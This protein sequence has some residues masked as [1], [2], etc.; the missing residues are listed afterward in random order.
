[1]SRTFNAISPA[2]NIAQKYG[3]DLLSPAHKAPLQSLLTKLYRKPVEL[4]LIKIRRPQLE[5]DVLASYVAQRLGDRVLQPR[6]VIRD[7]AWK[8][9]L[10][11]ARVVTELQQAKA[12]RGKTVSSTEVEKSSSFGP[13]RTQTKSII[14]GLNLSQ[15]SSIAVHAAGRLSKRIT[16]NRAQKKMARR[17]ANTKGAGYMMRGF[18]KSHTTVGNATGK[19]RIG[20]YGVRVDVGHT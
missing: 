12:Q 4:N 14:R 1:M 20:V 9:Q 11:S 13:L 7:A 2:A 19:R 5:S 15:V 18:Q 6:R 3:V 10:P 17:G 16:A 8:A